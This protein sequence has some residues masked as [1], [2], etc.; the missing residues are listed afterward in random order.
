M[1][2]GQSVKTIS[3]HAITQTASFFPTGSSSSPYQYS[4]LRSFVNNYGRKKL[5]KRAG[6]SHSGSG[7]GCIYSIYKWKKYALPKK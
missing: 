7:A 6:T 5:P 2:I 3:V 4:C 1:T